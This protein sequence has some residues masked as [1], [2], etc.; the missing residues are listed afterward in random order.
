MPKFIQIG[1]VPVRVTGGT[2]GREHDVLELFALG[3]DGKVY[4]YAF[5]TGGGWIEVK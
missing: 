5:D 3:D 4:R 1:A 2:H